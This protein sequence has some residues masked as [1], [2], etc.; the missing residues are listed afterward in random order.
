[1]HESLKYKIMYTKPGK[2]WML[3]GNFR[4]LEVPRISEY[5]QN[6]PESVFLSH[7]LLA[8]ELL[9]IKDIFEKK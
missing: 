1:M 5:F 4:S 2:S 6:D 8:K 9:C 3:S 7:S